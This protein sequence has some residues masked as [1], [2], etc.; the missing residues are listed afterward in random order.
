MPWTHPSTLTARGVAFHRRIG[1]RAARQAAAIVTP[2]EA[3]AAQVRE[4][5]D[6]VVPVVPVLSGVAIT[7]VPADA[8]LRRARLTRAGG[9]ASAVSG[10][11]GGAD[12]AYPY[13]LFVGTTEPR[14]GL[15]VA[16]LLYTS[17][18]V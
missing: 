12:A 6:P 7:P 14:K 10:P 18:C 17:R 15:D 11:A 3:V 4:L 1:A 2:T 8:A 16:C 9:S 13:V 5:L